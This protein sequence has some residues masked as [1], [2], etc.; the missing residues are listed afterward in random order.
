MQSLP[1]IGRLSIFAVVI[2][3]A[4][5]ISNQLLFQLC[6]LEDLRVWLYPWMAI[7]TAVLSW[8]TGR[9]RRSRLVGQLVVVE[10]RIARRAAVVPAGQRVSIG[11]QPLCD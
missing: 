10:H 5:A 4:V 8:C 3:A 6:S 11:T 2:P 7:S 9:L 1:S